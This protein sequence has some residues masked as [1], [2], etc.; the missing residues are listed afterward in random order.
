MN[1]ENSNKIN[2]DEAVALASDDNYYAA[3]DAVQALLGLPDAADALVEILDCGS[4]QARILALQA[5]P[6]IADDE[7]RALDEKLLRATAEQLQAEDEDTRFVAIRIMLRLAAVQLRESLPGVCATLINR[8][9]DDRL[10]RSDIATI[11]ADLCQQVPEATDLVIPAL[12]D[13]R[14]TVREGIARTICQIPVPVG[15]VGEDLEQL[16]ATDPDWSV[17]AWT[18]AAWEFVSGR[19]LPVEKWPVVSGIP[20]M[21]FFQT[22]NKDSVPAGARFE[23]SSPLI[24]VLKQE[25]DSPWL[26]W[27]DDHGITSSE[28]LLDDY[29]PIPVDGLADDASSLFGQHVE[30]TGTYRDYRI[31]AEQV[32]ARR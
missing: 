20:N 4:N 9:A 24:G 10:T 6:R 23:E 14:P 26:Y 1:S 2:R 27:P 7:T 21:V 31:V 25:G 30:V 22:D 28:R 11:L 16:V 5:V 32:E 17:R 12:R 15:R 19:R 3:R 29:G 18:A 13:K 8:F